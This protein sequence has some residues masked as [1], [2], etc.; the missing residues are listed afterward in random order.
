MSR[1]NHVTR[2]RVYN[3]RSSQNKKQRQTGIDKL[4]ITIS[5]YQQHDRGPRSVR[6]QTVVAKN[7]NRRTRGPWSSSQT[8]LLTI[9]EKCTFRFQ[10]TF[11]HNI[12]TITSRVDTSIITITR[13][14]IENTA[15]RE[16]S[17]NRPDVEAFTVNNRITRRR[18]GRREIV[19]LVIGRAYFGGPKRAP[20]T[21]MDDINSAGFRNVEAFGPTFSGGPSFS[22]TYIW[23]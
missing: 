2:A 23:Y 3:Y 1:R 12:T 6:R 10:T 7:E 9:Y 4:S 8:P 20:R 21:G 5:C 11:P 15:S 17:A 13:Y 16:I 19:R 22:I 18:V 14:L